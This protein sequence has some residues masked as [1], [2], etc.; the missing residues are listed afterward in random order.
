MS[1]N[2]VFK[3]TYNLCG[4]DWARCFSPNYDSQEALQSTTYEQ[5]DLL[6]PAQWLKNCIFSLYFFTQY[7]IES[8]FWD[9][10]FIYHEE[11][12]LFPQ[13]P[14]DF[15]LPLLNWS[16]WAKNLK[17]FINGAEHCV[18][19]SQ[20]RGSQMFFKRHCRICET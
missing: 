1:L 2:F 20:A 12:Q 19:V 13:E 5:V 17:K 16:F 15:I 4:H 10:I 9:S 14:L 3:N 11:N 8:Q 7:E 6:G 18:V